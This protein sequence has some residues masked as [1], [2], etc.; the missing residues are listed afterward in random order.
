[1]SYTGTG[2]PTNADRAE[3]AE[4]AIKVFA[5][6]VGE[7]SD[8]EADPETVLSDLIGDLMHYCD[9]RKVD[10]YEALRRGTNYHSEEVE[11]EEDN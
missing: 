11:E 7:D 4:K 1:M 5:V 3:W 9:I 2:E 6:E 8:L 10:W